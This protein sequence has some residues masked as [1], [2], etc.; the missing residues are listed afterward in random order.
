MFRLLNT[1]IRIFDSIKTI[2]ISI[3]SMAQHNITGKKGEDLACQ[4]LLSKGYTIR[5]CGWRYLKGEIDIIASKNNYCH[6]IE[7][8]T[9]MNNDYGAPHEAVNPQKERLIIDTADA[10]IQENDIEDEISFDIISIRLQPTLDIEH[11]IDAFRPEF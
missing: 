6:F 4:F 7:V 1:N 5:A 9:R 2:T 11:Y 10:Y 8:K 3:P